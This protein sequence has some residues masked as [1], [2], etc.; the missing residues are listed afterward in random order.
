MLD[1]H[2][3]NFKY[4]RTYMKRIAGG[5]SSTCGQEFETQ[6]ASRQQAI[7]CFYPTLIDNSRYNQDEQSMKK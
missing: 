4:R 6:L 3:V 7:E 5:S 1:L 2:F